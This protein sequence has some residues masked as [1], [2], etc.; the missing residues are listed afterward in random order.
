MLLEFSDDTK[1]AGIS[2]KRNGRISNGRNWILLRTQVTEVELN[3]M[4]QWIKT[5]I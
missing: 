2:I 5:H 1:W 4:V 3:A